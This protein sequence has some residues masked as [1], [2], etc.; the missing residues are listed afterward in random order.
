MI[1]RANPPKLYLDQGVFGTDF[2]SKTT[3]IIQINGRKI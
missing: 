1:W 3:L 2:W